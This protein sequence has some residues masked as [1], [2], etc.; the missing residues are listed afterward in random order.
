MDK[1]NA[2]F[3]RAALRGVTQISDWVEGL[4]TENKIK[5]SLPR[6]HSQTAEASY[7]APRLLKQ[8]LAEDPQISD[9]HRGYGYGYGYR[10]LAREP[11]VGPP[12]SGRHIRI[13]NSASQDN[14]K[15]CFFCLPNS[16]NIFSAV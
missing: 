9:W 10:D 8:P 12:R 2:S 6:S 16:G 13:L 11:R 14:N 1:R 5:L 15:F 3:S 7:L 4:K